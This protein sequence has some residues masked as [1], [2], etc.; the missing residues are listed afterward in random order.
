MGW[1]L[2]VRQSLRPGVALGKGLLQQYPFLTVLGISVLILP[3]FISSFWVITATEVFIFGLYAVS[4]NLLL[5]YGGMLSFGHAAYFGIGAYTTALLMKKAGFPMPLAFLAAPFVSAT[6]AGLLGFFCVRLRGVYFAMLTF[7][8]QMLI[9]TVIFKWYSFTGGDDGVS[10]VFPPAFIG[11]PI[12]YYYFAII[13]V[14]LGLILLY[15]IVNSPFGYAM[16]AIRE[17]LLR[18]KYV[19]INVTLYCWLTFVLAGFFAGLAGAL[20]AFSKSSVF[21]DWLYWTASAIPI[22]MAVFGGI[23]VFWGPVVG[24]AGYVLLETIITGFTQYWPMIMGIILLFLVI[25]IPNGLVSLVERR[26]FLK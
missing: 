11:S 10:G 13:M 24:A 1:P 14:I 22:F 9:Y 8:F 19:G 4:F 7:A 2:I 18:S 20:Y 25:L 5:G 15:M 21:P 16:K 17:S 6:A 3:H 23:Q 26:P 12:N